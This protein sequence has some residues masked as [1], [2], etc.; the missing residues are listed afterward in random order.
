MLSNSNRKITTMTTTMTKTT[1]TVIMEIIME[2]IVIIRLSLIIQAQICICI[3]KYKILIII[4]EIKKAYHFF[5]IV[6]ITFCGN[7]KV[8]HKVL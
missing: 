3:E 1:T 6:Y 2:I 8:S 7:N 4:M 5:V